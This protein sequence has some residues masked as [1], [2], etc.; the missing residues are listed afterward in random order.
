MSHQ[1]DTVSH[2]H[3]LQLFLSKG[4]LFIKVKQDIGGMVS[5]T[6]QQR[7]Q[8]KRTQLGDCIAPGNPQLAYD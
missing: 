4:M 6:Q 1:D 2:W 8:R 7:L 3:L 5:A